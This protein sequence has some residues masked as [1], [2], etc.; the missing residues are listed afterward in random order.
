MPI[1]QQLCSKCENLRFVFT[2]IDC[3][4]EA[5]NHFRNDHVSRPFNFRL[6][7]YTKTTTHAQDVQRSKETTNDYYREV[8]ACSICNEELSN[9][10]EWLTHYNANHQGRFKTARHHLKW[11]KRNNDDMTQHERLI[12]FKYDLRNGSGSSVSEELSNKADWLKEG[13][14]ST[15]F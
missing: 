9:K 2:F 3:R 6:M 10:A 14:P 5:I 1:H 12:L 4:I 11:M 13:F 7:K 8:F 15:R